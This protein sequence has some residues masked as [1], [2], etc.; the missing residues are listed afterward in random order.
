[1]TSL[2][3]AAGQASVPWLCVY[4]YFSP[5]KCLSFKTPIAH[6]KGRKG[7]GVGTEPRSRICPNVQGDP[8]NT[9]PHTLFNIHCARGSP[10]VSLGRGCCPSNPGQ[11]PSPPPSK[12]H[13]NR[14]GGTCPEFQRWQPEAAHL[15]NPLDQLRP[16]ALPSGVRQGEI[17][18][19]SSAVSKH[20]LAEHQH[21]CF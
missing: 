8:P 6:L 21:N 12:C 10:R 7:L 16:N 20:T 17:H 15:H 4:F 5:P 18:L 13:S 3:T 1:M 9:H 19:A 11:L 2:G 14:C